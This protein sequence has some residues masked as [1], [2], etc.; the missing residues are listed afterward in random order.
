MLKRYEYWYTK[1]IILLLK[2][3]YGCN[4]VITYCK[5]RILC[6]SR[7][8]RIDDIKSGF[9][10]LPLYSM[11]HEW[12]TSWKNRNTNFKS[13]EMSVPRNQWFH[14]IT[15]DL[16]F[17]KSNRLDYLFELQHTFDLFANGMCQLTEIA[18]AFAEIL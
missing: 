17:M 13:S 1:K 14:D 11:P 6:F 7:I 4:W 5:F 8:I 18:A 3:S 15:L 16:A 10:I 9:V 2:N 12:I